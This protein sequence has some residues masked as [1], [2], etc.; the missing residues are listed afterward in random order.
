MTLS[1]EQISNGNNI[2][3]QFCGYKFIQQKKGSK[4]YWFHEP[5][6]WS[7]V[8]NDLQFHK[9]FDKLIPVCK[10]CK[11]ILD[12]NKLE[13]QKELVS[14]WNDI[15]LCLGSMNIEELFLR[16]VEFIKLYKNPPEE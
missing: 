8:P 1:E 14:K 11:A 5:T 12:I 7:I 2:I 3:I 15:Y 9:S 13:N 6:Q 10:Q 16:V 4:W